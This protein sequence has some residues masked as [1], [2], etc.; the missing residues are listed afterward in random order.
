MKTAS[1]AR[2]ARTIRDRVA[3]AR[4]RLE[5]IW[6]S[7]QNLPA[8][9]AV[10]ILALSAP[11]LPW[12]VPNV[13]RLNPYSSVWVLAGFAGV[14]VTLIALVFAV[15][16]FRGQQ[17][18][19]HLPARVVGDEFLTPWHRGA[20]WRLASILCGSLV[21]LG[22]IEEGRMPSAIANVVMLN[23]ILLLMS[24]IGIQAGLQRIFGR[25]SSRQ[26][27][28]ATLRYVDDAYL[29]KQ[30]DPRGTLPPSMAS[31][32][33]TTDA[34]P[35][36]LVEQV[37]VRSMK[38]GDL[39]TAHLLLRA[40]VG[41]GME[42]LEANKSHARQVLG[43]IGEVLSV[44]GRK[45]LVEDERTAEVC[46]SLFGEVLEA[47]LDLKLQWH[48]R[49]ELLDSFRQLRHAAIRLKRA[50]VETR[51][52]WVFQSSFKQ[53]IAAAPAEASLRS[54]QGEGPDA[55]PDNTDLELEWDHI[56][57]NW[58]S[59]L[60][61]DMELCIAE[62]LPDLFS[63]GH[64]IQRFMA[65]DIKE[66][67]HLGSLQ[68]RE[69]LNYV[70]WEAKFAVSEAI[71]RGR[72]DAYVRWEMPHRVEFDDAAL[73]GV[74]RQALE[75]WSEIMVES[76]RA[77]VLPW[78]MLNGFTADG[79]GFAAS[80]QDDLAILVA[81]TLGS[82]AEPLA[83]APKGESRTR[84]LEAAAGLRSLSEWDKRP[85]SRVKEAVERELAK[86]TR[87]SEWLTEWR[88]ALPSRRRIPPG[89]WHSTPWA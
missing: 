53:A 18:A 37:C 46:V 76:A 83:Q 88:E 4:D 30:R 15:T 7:L 75:Q 52:M 57:D 32:V 50:S 55:P 67:T 1:R 25:N 64:F 51:A 74:V 48:E 21:A 54:L 78:I 10:F 63:T 28:R 40:V 2:L 9:I 70:I 20:I 41:R 24:L 42:Y 81:E 38:Q 19:S 23:L 73:D 12:S 16:T 22:P 35:F 47:T 44:I 27:V 60:Q 72:G 65:F 59:E 49:I 61:R 13:L 87:E 79:R 11:Y 8:L 58:I 71:R 56:R 68:K 36:S 89:Q 33:L 69:L 86:F 5:R 85:T 29:A 62:D 45:A 82:L 14:S 34:D 84:Y 26:M 66:S 39:T 17:L 3:I 6:I 80:G 43:W 31:G 77:G